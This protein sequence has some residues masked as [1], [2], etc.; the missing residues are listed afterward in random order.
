[1]VFA[2]VAASAAVGLWVALNS[3]AL[4][5][6]LV[7]LVIAFS[8]VVAAIAP[9]RW[10]FAVVFA[11]V[12]FS[13]LLKDLANYTIVSHLAND[14]VIAGLVVGHVI[15]ARLG[16]V[17]LIPRGLPFRLPLAILLVGSVLLSFLPGSTPIQA[18]GGWKAYVEPAILVP[19]AAVALSQPGSTEPSRW[20]LI[21]VGVAN[22][23]ASLWEA[24]LGPSLVAEWGPGFAHT[25]TGG[26]VFLDES[27]HGSW[28]PFGLAQDAGAASLFET[29]AALLL[30]QVALGRAK[31]PWT[32]RLSAFA[33]VLLL[34]YAI[35]SAGVRGSI[36]ALVIG[37]SVV[38]FFAGPRRPGARALSVGTLFL[39]GIGVAYVAYSVAAL[40]PALNFRITGLLDFQ[41]YV[42]SRGP[43]VG[44][45]GDEAQRPFGVGMGNNVPSAETLASFANQ[46]LQARANE[47]ILLS[48]MLELGWFGAAVVVTFVVEIVSAMV[49]Y[50]RRPVD[51]EVGQALHLCALMLIVGL[52]GPVLVAAPGNLIL[53]VFGAAAIYRLN[54]IRVANA[55][56]Q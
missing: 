10:G 38:L 21:I 50:A 13:G 46:T 7:Y 39:L 28:R 47:N 53:W 56:A 29:T 11:F 48:M 55:G 30:V 26:T 35:F 17:R 43:L 6:T 54:H 32:L 16:M 42:S 27:G 49:R 51:V 18:L 12:G 44:Y 4:L 5:T 1:M 15:R 19:I 23:I 2:L 34:A 9:Q 52:A 8:A 25:V 41:T 22:A 14:F 3:G 36:V 20:M 37:L 31:G 24:S 40:T 45:I 33:M